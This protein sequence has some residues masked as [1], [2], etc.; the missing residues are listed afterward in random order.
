MADVSAP[1]EAS[2]DVDQVI[3]SDTGEASREASREVDQVTESDAGS[4]MPVFSR[5]GFFSFLESWGSLPGR[6]RRR[7]RATVNQSPN[8]PNPK[9]FF[10]NERTFLS[11]MQLCLVLGGLAVGL[12]NFGDKVGQSA[13]VI[14]GVIAVMI[15]FYSLIQF[16]ARAE[17]LQHIEKGTAFE[18]MVGAL[19]LVAVVFLAVG[20]N[21]GLRFISNDQP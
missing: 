20:I 7:Q 19:V 18:D 1:D 5:T 9:V 2:R 4:D 3:D 10:A 17:R 21:F 13:G 12:L 11:W 6:R 15:M 14:F 16:W 8:P